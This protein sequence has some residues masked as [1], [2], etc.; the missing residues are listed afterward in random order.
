MLT[1]RLTNGHELA[2][3]YHPSMKV[4][5]YVRDHIA[6]VGGFKLVNEGRTMYQRVSANAVVLDFFARHRLLGDLI[7][8]NG[9]LIVLVSLGPSCGRMEG[10]ACPDG[11]EFDECSIC[12]EPSFDISLDCLHRFHAHCVG[13]VR[14]DAC[15]NCRAVFTQADCRRIDIQL[16][17][18]FC[19]LNPN[20][21]L[22]QLKL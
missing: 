13:G 12:L 15:P 11:G 21:G 3:E 9:K 5:Q 17:L 8:D 20:C 2:L 22:T 6:R 4:W 14:D 16:R 7:K 10:N 1:L 19:R 18:A